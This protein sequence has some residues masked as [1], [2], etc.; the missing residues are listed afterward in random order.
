MYNYSVNMACWP[1][2]G[3]TR[4]GPTSLNLT[5]PLLYGTVGASHLTFFL[6]RELSCFQKQGIKVPCRLIF[7]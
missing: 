7:V 5:S 4:W 6:T 2:S 1:A 3:L